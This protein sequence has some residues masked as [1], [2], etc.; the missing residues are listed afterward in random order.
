MSNDNTPDEAAPKRPKQRVLIAD[1]DP[2]M[3]RAIERVL[4]SAG[5]ETAVAHDGYAAEALF[6]TF[7]PSVM[8]LDL[9]MPGRAGMQVLNFIN[10]LQAMEQAP[11]CK[12]LIVSADA[13]VD[14]E[15]ALAVGAHGAV[16]KPFDNDDLLS[17]VVRLLA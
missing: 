6:Q 2:A 7:Q 3:A 17:E 16:S 11:R 8:T 10:S 14:D 13:Q 5:Y 15:L 12:V 9:R 1:D 4:H